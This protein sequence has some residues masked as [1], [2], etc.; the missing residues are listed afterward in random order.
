MLVADIMTTQNLVTIS[1][2]AS[3]RDAL[4]TMRER[5]VKSLIVDKLSPSDAY[6]ILTYKN[7]LQAIVAEEG[8][9]DLLNVYDICSKPA[10]QISKELNVKYAA[11]MM[12]NQS[13]KRIL[14][15]DNNELE[16]IL[17][18][19]NILEVLMKQARDI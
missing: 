3:I 13:I 18:M 12:V 5:K 7:I 11:Q 9:I 6:G 2:M 8:D 14:V 17:T 1:P 19:T 16:G 10:I 15:I 4:N